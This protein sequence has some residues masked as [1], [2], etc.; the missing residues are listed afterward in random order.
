[1]EEIEPFLNELCRLAMHDWI[2]P[3]VTT[4][5]HAGLRKSEL[6]RLRN[7]DVDFDAM[8]ITVRISKRTKG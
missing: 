6:I 8:V 3:I 1:M 5:A 7:S 2:N 4:P